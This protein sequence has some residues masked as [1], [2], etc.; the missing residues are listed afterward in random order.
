MNFFAF[1]T[2][3]NGERELVTP[4]LDGT[5]LPG[6]TRDSILQMA[7]EWGEFKVSERAITMA[8][9]IKAVQD[10]RLHE[11]FGAGTA[12]IVSPIKKIFYEGNDIMIPLDPS[13]PK[14][15]AGP[16]TRR[17]ADAIMGIQYGEIPH[18]WSVLVDKK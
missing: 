16:L 7:R 9:V 5:I 1:L 8:E 14:S 6:V 12:A 11:L 2:N 3:E 10:S 18:K 4:P 17:F 13:D 15:Q